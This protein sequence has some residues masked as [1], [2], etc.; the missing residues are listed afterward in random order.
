MN[1]VKNFKIGDRVLI[2]KNLA[3]IAKDRDAISVGHNSGMNQY[4]DH[5][6]FITDIENDGDGN[7]YYC[8]D[9]DGGC[10][11]WQDGF[12]EKAKF[13]KDALKTGMRV[14]YKEGG[15]RLV[16]LNWLNGH[17]MLIGHD[18]KLV[19]NRI[20]SDLTYLGEE[21]NPHTII[22]VATPTCRNTDIFEYLHCDGNWKQVWKRGS[23]KIDG[24]FVLQD[25]SKITIEIDRSQ[26]NYDKLTK[27]EAVLLTRDMWQW[28]SEDGSRDKEDYLRKYQIPDS[29]RSNCFLCEFNIQQGSGCINCSNCLLDW[30]NAYEM[31]PCEQPGVCYQR[32]RDASDI[33]TIEESAKELAQL[34]IKKEA[35]NKF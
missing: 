10:W 22:E 25:T 14:T 16:M 17:D 33:E 8:L 4:E 20:Y 6:T 3:E 24:D 29:I 35:W 27:E 13:S 11:S 34:P 5:T 31:A 23:N 21:D 2:R 28:L 18:G 32:W 12:L 26:I 1:R 9:I 30:G 7:L 15:H 19:L